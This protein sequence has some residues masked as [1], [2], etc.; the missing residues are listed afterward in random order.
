M[1]LIA[2]DNL[3]SESFMIGAGED[4]EGKQGLTFMNIF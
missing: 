1:P 4:D 3:I 2:G